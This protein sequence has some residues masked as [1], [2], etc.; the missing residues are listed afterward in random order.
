MKTKTITIGGMR[1]VSCATLNER[2]LKKIE[3]VKNASVNFATHK[4]IVEY[5]EDLASEK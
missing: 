4:A 2:A 3:G 5:D 1:C